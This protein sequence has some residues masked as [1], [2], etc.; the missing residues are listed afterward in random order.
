MTTH[1]PRDDDVYTREI[2]DIRYGKEDGFI[3]KCVLYGLFGL[4]AGISVFYTLGNAAYY[5][6][7]NK[8]NG[9]P[10]PSGI[11]TGE[12]P[13]FFAQ[14]KHLNPNQFGGAGGF[15]MTEYEPR[16]EIEMEHPNTTD[17]DYEKYLYFGKWLFPRTVNL[18]FCYPKGQ[19]G[20]RGQDKRK[21]KKNPNKNDPNKGGGGGG[22]GGGSG[23]SGSGGGGGFGGGFPPVPLPEIEEEEIEPIIQEILEED[24]DELTDAINDKK[25]PLDEMF[26]NWWKT[27]TTNQTSALYQ[28][29]SRLGNFFARN[30]RNIITKTTANPLFK[31]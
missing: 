12:A 2:C 25:P 26:K 4:G 7:L 8:Y 14:T 20:K 13:K 28:N 5:W 29:A 24:E 30:T 27:A 11:Y 16:I 6:L 9:T 22:S 18:T 21:R 15:S 1:N 3:D 17:R 10:I 31:A 23:G 19:T